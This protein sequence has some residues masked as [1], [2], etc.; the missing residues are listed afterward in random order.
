[1]FAASR[2]IT[3]TVCANLVRSDFAGRLA[4]GIRQR[5]LIPVAPIDWRVNEVVMDLFDSGELD[6]TSC[7]WVSPGLFV[8]R[9]MHAAS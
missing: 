5:G 3:N 9:S 1:V 7:L 8:Q 2:P 4:A 6:A